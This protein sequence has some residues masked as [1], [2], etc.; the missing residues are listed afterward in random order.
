MIPGPRVAAPPLGKDCLPPTMWDK[1]DATPYG[2][3]DKMMAASTKP[4]NESKEKLRR[5]T[6]P[7]DHFNFERTRSA[8]NQEFPKP[9]RTFHSVVKR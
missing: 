6:V 9:K 5:S 8:I 2:R 7:F 1:L 4:V 3:F